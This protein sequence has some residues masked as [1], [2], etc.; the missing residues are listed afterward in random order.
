MFTGLHEPEL[1]EVDSFSIREV[2]R[3]Q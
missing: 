2:R 3:G 1:P